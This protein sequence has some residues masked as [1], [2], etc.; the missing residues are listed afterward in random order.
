MHSAP[1][2]MT[3]VESFGLLPIM[4]AAWLIAGDRAMMESLFSPRYTR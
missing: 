4:A 2:A 3:A 1:R